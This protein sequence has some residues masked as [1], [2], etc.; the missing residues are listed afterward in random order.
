[1]S[2]TFLFCDDNP[3]KLFRL[4]D[5]LGLVAWGDVSGRLG[6]T[7]LPSIA[8]NRFAAA[9]ID[10]RRLPDVVLIDDQVEFAAGAPR[11]RNGVRTMAAFSRLL[12]TFP[13]G[14]ADPTTFV[15]LTHVDPND[16]DRL[17]FMEFG[18]TGIADRQD[19]AAVPQAIRNAIHAAS[20]RATSWQ[21]ARVPELGEIHGNR[22]FWRELF[23]LLPLLDDG[24]LTDNALIK[25]HLD[26]GNGDKSPRRATH[27]LSDR[28]DALKAQLRR[29]IALTAGTSRLEKSALRT[30]AEIVEAAKALGLI[31]FTEQGRRDANNI[32]WADI[33][34]DA[35][36]R[37]PIRPLRLRSD[38]E[39]TLGQQWYLHRDDPRR[40]GGASYYPSPWGGDR[41]GS[42]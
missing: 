9:L 8:I 29:G 4:P 3:E 31:W 41:G 2:R 39:P 18:G 23:P 40:Q 22:D 42:S 25:R 34:P 13:R 37:T 26:L 10:R 11:T 6:G 12:D 14:G 38:R 21:P 16:N 20:R 24:L 30:D 27:Q 1:M 5:T 15:L 7:V 17:T 28:K 33:L 36:K 32:P 35:A 19:H